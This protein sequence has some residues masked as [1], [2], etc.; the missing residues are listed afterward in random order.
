MS[1]RFQLVGKQLVLEVAKGGLVKGCLVLA[2]NSED[3]TSHVVEAN[4]FKNN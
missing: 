3:R 1:S 2:Q 4:L